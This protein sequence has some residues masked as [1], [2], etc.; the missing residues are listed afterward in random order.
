MRGA[1]EITV[2]KISVSDTNSGYWHLSNTELL[3][4]DK[5]VDQNLFDFT[6]SPPSL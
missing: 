5:N 6:E 2:T 1:K 3:K 4:R